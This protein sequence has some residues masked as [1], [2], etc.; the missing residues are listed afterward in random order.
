MS[1]PN[2]YLLEVLP[3]VAFMSTDYG[4]TPA[5]CLDLGG[6]NGDLRR[7]I[8]ARGYFYV[9]VDIKDDADVIA[10]VHELPFRDE[11][12]HIVISKDSLEHFYAPKQAVAEA[13][14]V[15][16]NYHW[17]LIIVPWMHP[18]HRDDYWRFSPEGLRCMLSDVALVVAKMDSPLWLFTMLSVMVNRMLPF[19]HFPLFR[20]CLRKAGYFL[21]RL[22]APEM[23]AFAA[24]YRVA[25][26]KTF[27]IVGGS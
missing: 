3:S 1:T 15:L 18:H 5:Y 26:R 22:F 25:A 2:K 11:C 14:R 6:G 8:E 21:D 19:R 20:H 4:A 9:I 7:A 16:K 17:L 27:H 13:A 24:S 23:S 12:I 10:D